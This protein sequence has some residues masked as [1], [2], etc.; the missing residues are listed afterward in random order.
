MIINNDILPIFVGHQVMTYDEWPVVG[1]SRLRDE[2]RES[3][4][5]H[6]RCRQPDQVRIDRELRLDLLKYDARLDQIFVE[7]CVTAD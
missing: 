3:K 2:V 7:L 5:R 4:L 1:S 6:V